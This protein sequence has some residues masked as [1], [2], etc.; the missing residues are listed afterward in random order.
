MNLRLQGAYLRGKIEGGFWKISLSHL[1]YNQV[2]ISCRLLD[3]R[4]LQFE[5]WSGDRNKG[6]IFL[7][8]MVSPM[9]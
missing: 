1:L 7:G 9:K 8:E 5:H 3:I 2:E 4:S 6:V